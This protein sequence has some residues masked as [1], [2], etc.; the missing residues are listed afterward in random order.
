LD[1]VLL[2]ALAN[3][4]VTRRYAEGETIFE[5]GEAADSLYVILRG[6]VDVS[7]I[8]PTG[9]ERRLA[10]LRDGDY[11]GE[12]ALLHDLPRTATVRARASTLLLALDR[13][14]FFTLLNT[15]PDL[16]SAFE[17]VVEARWRENLAAVSG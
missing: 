10:V 4:I 14:Q 16:R 12:M 15:V 11:F 6:Q 7:T 3:R 8:G 13:E 1:G 17:R 2:A 5:E 9:K